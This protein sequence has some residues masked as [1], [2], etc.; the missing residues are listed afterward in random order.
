[1]R[2]LTR[3][4]F[5]AAGAAMLAP[6]QHPNRAFAQKPSALQLA[7]QRRTLDINGPTWG[8]HMPVTAT[9]GERV[10]LTFHN[11]SMMGHPMHLHGHAFQ[12]AA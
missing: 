9:R 11:M 8:K 6:T 12:V 3:R 7:A 4:G 10:E 5:L 2:T 1:M